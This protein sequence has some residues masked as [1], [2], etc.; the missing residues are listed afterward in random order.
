MNARSVQESPGANAG[1]RLRTRSVSKSGS[2]EDSIQRNVQPKERWP[3]PSSMGFSLD[4]QHASCVASLAARMVITTAM[5][6]KTSLPSGGCAGDVTTEY[7][8]RSARSAVSNHKQHKW[9]K[10]WNNIKNRTEG[11]SQSLRGK[12]CG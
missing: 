7:T 2:G 6:K 4:Q 9:G 3:S 12:G 11:I 5:K 10:L 1:E 8:L